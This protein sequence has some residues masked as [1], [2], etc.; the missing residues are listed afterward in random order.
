MLL[1][2]TIVVC[3]LFHACLCIS[4]NGSSEVS[5][6]PTWTY[7]TPPNN[8]CVCGDGIDGSI[9]C[10]PDTLTVSITKKYMCMFFSEELQTMFAGTCPYNIYV[11]GNVPRNISQSMEGNTH[12]QFCF[13]DH[14]HREGPLCGEC[15]ENY[16]LPAYSYYLG[17]I[18]CESYKNGWIKFVAAA[19]LPVTL[20]YIIVITFRL[21][22]TSSSLN[23]FV[24]IHQ[25][26]A[27]PP[28]VR[29]IYSSNHVN[30]LYYTSY[31]KQYYFVDF[32]IAF[33]RFGT[34]T[35]FG[36]CMDLFVSTLT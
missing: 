16:T 22:I 11:G 5:V 7:P 34:L 26:L 15:E 9:S 6:C 33:L 1:L 3:I 31:A 35:S 30:D 21:S 18:K 13:H 19:F 28:V 23:V 10:D 12:D 14:M 29:R 27:I 8:E 32:I 4:I 20:F 17:C 2:A 36:A 25:V 24:M